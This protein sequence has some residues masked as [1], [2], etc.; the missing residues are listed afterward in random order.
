MLVFFLFHYDH[1][2][3]DPPVFFSVCEEFHPQNLDDKPV[4]HVEATKQR[5]MMII[6]S[7]ATMACVGF[8]IH[9]EVWQKLGRILLVTLFSVGAFIFW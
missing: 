4:L 6:R 8:K 2:A 1:V 3:H 9:L 5:P 7:R